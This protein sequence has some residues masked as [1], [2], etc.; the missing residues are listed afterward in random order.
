M[1]T[2]RWRYLCLAALWPLAAVSADTPLV[3]HDAWVR[4][5]PPTAHDQAD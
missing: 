3:L 2:R 5:L 1:P 4:A